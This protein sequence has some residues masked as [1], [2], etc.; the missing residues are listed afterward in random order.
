MHQ[1]E[2]RTPIIESSIVCLTRWKHYRDHVFYAREVAS[3]FNTGQLTHTRAF[4]NTLDQIFFGSI[5]A[6]YFVIVLRSMFEDIIYIYIYVD[7]RYSSLPR[8]R[9]HISAM[10]IKLSAVQLDTPVLA[11]ARAPHG[12]K[13][14]RITRRRWN[15]C[16]RGNDIPSP[17]WL[18][19][20][21][22]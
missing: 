11:E 12:S 13:I 20:R 2:D 22:T 15:V 5:Y 7:R 1:R 3:S 21:S 4:H 16:W 9:W 10:E 19:F 8:Y 14:T 17:L 6:R 18:I